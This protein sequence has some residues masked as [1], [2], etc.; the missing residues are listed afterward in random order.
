MNLKSVRVSNSTKSR[1][2]NR[3]TQNDEFFLSSRT[4]NSQ[5]RSNDTS[6][7]FFFEYSRKSKGTKISRNKTARNKSKKAETKNV[8]N[9]S[10]LEDLPKQGTLGQEMLPNFQQTC[11]LQASNDVK[12]RNASTVKKSIESYRERIIKSSYGQDTIESCKKKRK[13]KKKTGS[14]KKQSKLV[15]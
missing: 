4:D 8:E 12:A 6:E 14:S 3:G 1:N 9:F 10:F 5:L 7:D 2:Q 11:D 15:S 13:K